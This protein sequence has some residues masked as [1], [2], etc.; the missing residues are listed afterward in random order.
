MVGCQLV[1]HTP[2]S[3]TVHLCVENTGQEQAVWAALRNGLAAFLAEHGA[4]NVRIEKAAEPPAL[5]PRAESSA[6]L[7]RAQRTARPARSS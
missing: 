7:H 1:Q 5:H 6:G 4:T 3:L 2:S